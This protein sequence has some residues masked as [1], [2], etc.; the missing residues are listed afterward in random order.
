MSTIVPVRYLT[1]PDESTWSR[2]IDLDIIRLDG[3]DNLVG[4]TR[5]DGALQ[6]WDIS[7]PIIDT[8]ALHR[9]QGGDVAGGGG[10]V[11]TL[12]TAAGPVLLTGGG[13]DGAF[14]QISL[15]GG[16]WQVIDSLP[17]FAGFRPDLVVHQGGAQFVYGG[18]ADAAGIAGWHFD[19]GGTF[20]GPLATITT[21]GKVHAITSA[22][23]FVYSV[24][25]TNRLTGWQ[26]DATGGLSEITALTAESGLWIADATALQTSV[27]AGVTYLVM[28]AAG[29]SSLTVIEVG[30]QGALTIRDHVMDTLQTRF[31]GAT[32]LDIVTEGGRSYV[33]AGGADDGISVFAL[34]P[35]GQLVALAHIADTTEIGLDNV[36]AIAAR[37]AEDR[38]DIFVASSSETGITQL[39]LDTGG[40]GITAT[41]TLAGGLLSGTGGDDILLGG[42]GD[43]LILGG[44]GH[45]IL[46]DGAGEDILT[47][48]PGAD[49]FILV[50]DGQT[51]TITDFTL[52][53]DRLDLSL[54]PM[55]RDISQ[56]TMA[57]TPTGFII[58]YGDEDLII[59]SA[60]GNPIDYRLL[61]NADV[62][63][64]MRL[65]GTL[66]PGFPGPETPPPA[67]TPTP[68][69]IAPDQG[70][71]FSMQAAKRALVDSKITDLRSAL[72][73]QPA[74]PPSS[75]KVVTG[76]QGNDVLIGGAGADVFIFN[77]G[78][79]VI[80]DF[81]QGIDRIILD[82]R[83][84]T[85]LTSAADLLLVYGRQDG[86]RVTID[87]GNNDIL[88]ID[89]VT[90]YATLANDIALF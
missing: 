25:A 82:A 86:A 80:A 1:T 5:F 24:D 63:G 66:S 62:L 19:A 26:V 47:G 48:G 56:L 39:R 76:T 7:D 37:S 89:G 71:P 4:I 61:S 57:I 51:D 49:V 52:G 75:D 55:L 43:D 44:A 87:F 88:M 68:P 8:G 30:A 46:R 42:A 64:G 13:A 11:L 58:R 2:I 6:S 59:H 32:A 23:G 3:T 35:G 79:D 28:A 73:N 65:P 12:D 17:I 9:L 78:R 85:G 20:I 83:L 38:L 27:V 90:D 18:L 72:Q 53:E 33:I 29:S 34:L 10:S 40:A 67:L 15:T 77:H 14:Q 45:D 84:W 81:E 36:S 54:W 21:G 41:A 69:D 60:D 74:A 31:G 22:D 70:D 50:A 16:A